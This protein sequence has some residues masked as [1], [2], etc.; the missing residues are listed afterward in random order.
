MILERQSSSEVKMGRDSTICKKLHLQTV[1]HFNCFIVFLLIIKFS[2]CYSLQYITS[3]KMSVCKG[4]GW[5][6]IL[7]A[8]LKTVVE[9]IVW[10]LPRFQKSL[11]VNTLH[12][13][14]YQCSLKFCHVKKSCVSMIQKHFCL[15]WA[16]THLK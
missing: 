6:P 11:S 7:D 3:G 5:K 14:V 13:G 15:L 1:E 4:Q 16:K 8:H 2:G 12:R 10:T 9:I